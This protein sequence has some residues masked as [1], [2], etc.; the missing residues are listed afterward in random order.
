MNRRAA[1]LMTPGMV[2]H[3]GWFDF[4]S[5]DWYASVVGA[6][7]RLTLPVARPATRYLDPL[8]LN[9]AV[10]LPEGS[11][12]IGDVA[13]PSETPAASNASCRS[14]ALP[15]EGGMVPATT[16]GSLR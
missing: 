15:A 13:L 9:V 6:A 11:G 16:I 10:N 4:D 12:L 5:N 7:S 2:F 3:A 14:L 8:V 1:M